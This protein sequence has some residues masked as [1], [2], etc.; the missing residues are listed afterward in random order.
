MKTAKSYIIIVIYQGMYVIRINSNKLM[1]INSILGYSDSATQFE[2]RVGLDDRC[3]PT[4][5]LNTLM[6]IQNRRHISDDIFEYISWIKIVVLWIKC[7]WESLVQVT[8]SHHWSRNVLVQLR[9]KA[10]G[11]ITFIDIC[12]S[13]YIYIMNIYIRFSE[14]F[15]YRWS[16]YLPF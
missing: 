12:I 14:G 2:T 16:Q 15:K 1:S 5:D 8:I 9:W 11:W 13:I 6:L 7:H 10:R 3:V 4:K